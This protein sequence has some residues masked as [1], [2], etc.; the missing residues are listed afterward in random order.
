MFNHSDSYR[1]NENLEAFRQAVEENRGNHAWIHALVASHPEF[2]QSHQITEQF[3]GVFAA[4]GIAHNPE[5]LNQVY[6][7]AR[8]RS[9]EVAGI[10]GG[11]AAS[12]ELRKANNALKSSVIKCQEHF[13]VDDS[14]MTDQRILRR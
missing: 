9:Q 11:L 1:I 14:Y 8:V 2:A 5:T 13:R 6:E 7:T 10:L 3:R 4:L 12:P